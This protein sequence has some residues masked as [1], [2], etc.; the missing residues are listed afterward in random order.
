MKNKLKGELLNGLEKSR[1]RESKDTDLL[2]GTGMT[3]SV[4]PPVLEYQPS[5]YVSHCRLPEA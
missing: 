4:A 3:P 2:T 5:Y 1:E